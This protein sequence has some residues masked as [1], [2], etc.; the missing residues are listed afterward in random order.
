MIIDYLNSIYP[1]SEEL[2]EYLSKVVRFQEVKRKQF[3][4]K[5]GQVSR[6]IYFIWKGIV[7][8][9]YV[10]D[11]GEEV[12]ARFMMEGNAVAPILSFFQQVQSYESLIA[13]E[14]CE[15][16]ALS[17][18]DM[19]YCRRKYLEFNF[20][21]FELIKRNYL[22]S[23]ERLLIIR[24]RTAEER[25]NLLRDR[26]PKLLQRV[27]KKHIASYLDLAPW[28]ISRKDP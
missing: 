13:F 16:Y 22:Q 1:M 4:L 2:K 23:E 12:S 14:D 28:S 9:Y 11:T 27:P 15:L 10:L 8:C 24:R 19:E 20:I 5:E 17:Y 18:E 3:L 6:D 25:Y 26:W 7:R 21:A